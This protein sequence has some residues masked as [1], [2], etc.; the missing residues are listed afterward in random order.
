MRDAE[1][2]YLSAVIQINYS[3][4]YSVVSARRESQRCNSDL[5]RV[6]QD[7]RH[8]ENQIKRMRE[9]ILITR[10]NL[11]GKCAQFLNFCLQKAL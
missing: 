6:E 11:Q 5:R 9:D 7:L 1:K 8:E 2:N 4:I 10:R 3:T